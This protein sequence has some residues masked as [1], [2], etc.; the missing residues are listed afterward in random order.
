MSQLVSAMNHELEEKAKLWDE[1][2]DMWG[3]VSPL[4]GRDVQCRL[5][6]ESLRARI[7]TTTPERREG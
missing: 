6:A 7:T 1:L 5:K 4:S 3:D 2:A